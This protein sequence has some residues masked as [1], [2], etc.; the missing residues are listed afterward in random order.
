VIRILIAD[1]HAIFRR[2]LKEILSRELK[3]VICGQAED[4]QQ[5][6]MQVQTE[7]WDLLILDITMPGA[8]GLDVVED[9]I[10][11]KP[12]LPVLVLSMHP[13]DHYGPRAIRAGAA[14]YV[15]KR[16]APE[17]LIKAIHKVLG[18]GCYLTP[19]LAEKIAIDL[20]AY[21]QRAPHEALSGREFAIFR[22]I[23]YGKTVG[24]I[25][26]EL[27]LSVTTVSTYRARILEK[28]SIATNADIIRYALLNHLV[29]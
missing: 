24:Q 6:S 2:G 12:K 29:D 1:D 11:V 10:R 4:A 18:G 17:E 13:E 15:M 23:A 7:N 28:M 8:S 3:D 16:S 19:S 5:V 22:M 25:S 26:K 20:R 9:L 14:G 21:T 27:H